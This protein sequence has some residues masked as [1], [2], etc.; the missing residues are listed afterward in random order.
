MIDNS[1]PVLKRI[2]QINGRNDLDTVDTF[3]FKDLYTKIPHAELKKQLVWVI[4]LAF[5]HARG[6]D[7]NNEYF[8]KPAGKKLGAI[9]VTKK[10]K[11]SVSEQQLVD[12]VNYLIEHIF[13]KVGPKCFRQVVGIPMGTDCG[14]LLANLYLFSR[15][16]QWLVEKWDKKGKDAA[17]WKK[18]RSLARSF[19]NT[20][21]Y[22]DDLI[23]FNN[24]NTLE[25]IWRDMYPF[26]TLEKTNVESN[27]CDFLDL[28]LGITNGGMRK[29]PYDKRDDF[30]FW[31]VS[32]PNLA[33]NI[34]FRSSHGV[35]ISQLIR[36]MRNCDFYADFCLKAKLLFERLVRQGFSKRLLRRGIEKFYEKY[37]GLLG[38]YT[39]S[40]SSELVKDITKGL[41]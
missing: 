10:T 26:L 35:F 39:L 6:T 16:Y 21:R 23:T 38:K 4:S 40:S 24:R 31:I 27:A 3:D 13:I 37:H 36:F 29:K 34:C 20:F 41:F 22:I 14:P 15:E 19:A 2:D 33:S 32:F 8:L 5:T 9:F 28:N 17:V 12:M 1:L 7:V 11:D 25:G 18:N 30:N